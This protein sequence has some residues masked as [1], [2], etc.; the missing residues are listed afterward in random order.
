M[1]VTLPPRVPCG[2]LRA[3]A[4]KSAA[5][6][7]LICASFADT[8]TRIRCEQ[9]NRDIE[10]TV[11]CLCSLGAKITRDGEYFTVTPIKSVPAKARLHCGESGSTL[12]FLLP[13]VASLGVKGEF[14]LEGRLADR[15]LSPLR[16]ELVA[17]GITLSP[18]GSNPLVC[19]GKLSGNSFSIAGNVSSQ[20]ISGLLFALSLCM[21]GGKLDVTENIESL[22]YVD[23]TCNALTEFGIRIDK[24][25]N[26]YTVFRPYGIT[27]PK[28]VKV[29]GDWSN[30][31]FPLCAAAIGGDVTLHGISLSSSQGDKRIT[32]L[33]RDFGANVEEGEDLVRVSHA[34]LCAIDIDA[35]DIPDLVP[36]LATV[37]S[38][39]KGTTKIYGAS[40]LRIKES[41]R[42]KTVSEML[43]SLGA[44]IEETADGLIISGKERLSGGTVSSA[45]DH[46]IAMSAAVASVACASPVTILG[47][48]ACAKSYPSFFE[49][50]QGLWRN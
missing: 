34:P 38:V 44:D 42:L 18:Q 12:R 48:D 36:V 46:R 50:M 35:T 31:A 47:A 17:H 7:L 21:D 26:S 1:N 22:P 13:I 32:E 4:S 45:N 10:A 29:E 49:D 20:F 43:R 15:P 24:N 27:S 28:E 37:A 16:E 14:I 41:D 40:R 11:S 2:S 30:A 9:L 33:L 3:I 39:A 8:P 5:H 23:M 6:R 25:G 19:E